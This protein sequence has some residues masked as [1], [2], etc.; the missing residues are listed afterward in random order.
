MNGKYFHNTQAF[1]KDSNLENHVNTLLEWILKGT[2]AK[3]SW[4][5]RF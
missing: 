1:P 4:L 2:S 3:L 5:A